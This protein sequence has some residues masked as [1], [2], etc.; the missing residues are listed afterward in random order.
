[1]T[2]NNDDSFSSSKAEVFEALGHPTRIRILQELSSGPLTYSE[3]KRAA[4]MESNGL[5]TF[6][7]GK[8]RG[9]VR[10]NPEGNYALT[11]EGRE[12]LRMVEASRK[13]PEIHPGKGTTIHLPHQRAILAGLLVALIVV[14]SVA[15]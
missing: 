11:D 14:G 1:M 9:L 3:L 5:L 15:V 10:L 2:E 13:Q 12:A 7:L 6:H 4:G 8:L